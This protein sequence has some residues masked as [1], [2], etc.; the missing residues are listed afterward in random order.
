M[1]L[2]T[3]ALKYQRN[4][5]HAVKV[6]AVTLAEVRHCRL[7]VG[8]CGLGVACEVSD[9]KNFSKALPVRLWYVKFFVI[10]VH[11]NKLVG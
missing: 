7:N 11:Q 10:G 6:L 9:H 8:D 3:V 1:E 4:I 5:R 2:G